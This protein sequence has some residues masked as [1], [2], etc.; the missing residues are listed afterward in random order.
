MY[1]FVKMFHSLRYSSIEKKIKI[2]STI[3]YR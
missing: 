2:Q 3:I 1:V